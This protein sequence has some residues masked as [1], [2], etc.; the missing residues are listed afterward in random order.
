MPHVT[1]A[2]TMSTWSNPASTASSA[3]TPTVSSTGAGPSGLSPQTSIIIHIISG[4]CTGILLVA[5]LL[6]L[7]RCR[8]IKEEKKHGNWQS[9]NSGGGVRHHVLR[10]ANVTA[11]TTDSVSTRSVRTETNNRQQRSRVMRAKGE[12][13]ERVLGLNVEL[14]EVSPLR[15][16]SHITIATTA[17]GGYDEEEVE[18]VEGGLTATP[19]ELL[20]PLTYVPPP[21]RARTGMAS[22]LA[23]PQQTVQQQAASPAEADHGGGIE[24]TIDTLGAS[25]AA[26]L[27]EAIAA[28]LDR[29]PPPPPPSI[30][31]QPAELQGDT[32]VEEKCLAADMRAA[33]VPLRM[34]F[35]ARSQA[36]VA[37]QF[38]PTPTKAPE[39]P[40]PPLQP[41]TGTAASAAK[42]PPPQ[43]RPSLWTRPS[44][45][46]ITGP[47]PAAPMPPPLKLPSWRQNKDRPARMAE[48]GLQEQQLFIQQLQRLA[49]G[50]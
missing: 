7:W 22:T 36:G 9:W 41:R 14:G 31:Q 35:L 27:A 33:T 21:S 30:P 5:V 47:S 2:N 37:Q 38:E 26:A 29:P 17:T 19:P 12:K 13:C 39:E 23:I 46:S 48:G 28:A 32:A 20:R 49:R 4:I 18:D 10:K 43:H 3:P 42:S 16:Q 24:D 40:L 34:R 1:S 25:A 45:M 50:P 6:L 44:T 8:R 15:R 11:S